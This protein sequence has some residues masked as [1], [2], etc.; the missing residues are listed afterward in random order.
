M[1]LEAGLDGPGI[2]IL[3]S[4]NDLFPMGN[5]I[6][7]CKGGFLTVVGISVTLDGS[8]GHLVG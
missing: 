6:C 7:L 8:A 3:W 1:V 2:H 5:L 4:C